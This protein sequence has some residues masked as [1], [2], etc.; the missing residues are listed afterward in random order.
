MRS[1]SRSAAFSNSAARSAA[2]ARDGEVELLR[3]SVFDRGHRL[4]FALGHR[5]RCKVPQTLL[6]AQIHA[7]GVLA[8]GIEVARQRN[9]R[10]GHIGLG[11]GI[12]RVGDER[13]H[14]NF[15]IS[16]LVHEGGVGPVLEQPPD[17]VGQ[18]IGE[19]AD[20][21]VDAA[22][23]GAFGKKGVVERI[24]HSKELLKL[25]ISPEVQDGGHS[26]AIVG[27]ES[28]FDVVRRR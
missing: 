8:V 7:Q 10:L 9:A 5:A 13:L 17:Q 23:D 12:E 15:G 24:A 26:P 22:W 3:R 21:C 1:S 6:V 11:Q 2:G 20:R 14:R 27:G 28:R 16:D 4:G 25:E 19:A 18:E